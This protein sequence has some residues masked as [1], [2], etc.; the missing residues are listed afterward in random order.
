MNAKTPEYQ[1][2]VIHLKFFLQRVYATSTAK[3]TGITR[4]YDQALLAHLQQD[5]T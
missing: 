3:T 2:L 1:R 4:P 5:Y